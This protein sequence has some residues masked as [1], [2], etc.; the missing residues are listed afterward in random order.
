M[1][2]TKKNTIAILWNCSQ[3]FFGRK[4]IGVY[5][6]VLILF[7]RYDFFGDP[8]SSNASAGNGML[9][10]TCR[11]AWV[12][13]SSPC[14]SSFGSFSRSAP[15]VLPEFLFF[16]LP[17]DARR[18]KR[19]RMDN[20]ARLAFFPFLCWVAHRRRLVGVGA[21]AAVGGGDSQ[22]SAASFSSSVA[23]VTT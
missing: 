13:S 5:F 20:R 21:G 10:W 19:P 9:K 7:L 16:S 12:S 23:M 1:I 3:M 17:R 15:S 11:C 18:L 14:P 22:A 8:S 2:S 6:A 4:L